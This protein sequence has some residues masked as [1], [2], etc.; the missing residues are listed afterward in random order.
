MSPLGSVGPVLEQFHQ[1]QDSRLI[2]ILND[3]DMSISPNVGGLSNHLTQ[4]LTSDVASGLR[5]GGNG[6]IA[7]DIPLSATSSSRA[8]SRSTSASS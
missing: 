8:P 1:I 3:N 2:V 4:L 7:L 6:Y 5:E